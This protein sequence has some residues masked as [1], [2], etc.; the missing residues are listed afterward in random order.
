MVPFSRLL[1]ALSDIPDPRRA[2]G[3]RYSPMAMV[4]RLFGEVVGL[5]VV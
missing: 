2:Q 4:S 1:A 5:M 3:K